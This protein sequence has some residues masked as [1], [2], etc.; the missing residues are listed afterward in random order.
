MN[1]CSFSGRLVADPVLKVFDSGMQVARFTI[2]VNR[3]FKN[4][5]GQWENDP[6][7]LDM[8]VWDSSAKIFV[9]RYKKGD[10]V[11]I[12]DASVRTDRWVDK[13]G[14]NRSKLC[15]RCNNYEFVPGANSLHE[16]T[17]AQEGEPPVRKAGKQTAPRQ[18][19]E[20]AAGKNS[21]PVDYNEIK[22]FENDEIP[23]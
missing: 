16:G 1:N 2:A 15:F 14:K 9:E 3:R 7:F 21:L 4:K 20:A 13:E 23:F 17:H 18:T 19:V 11:L 6:S 8:E 10:Y 12:T 22:D 5:D